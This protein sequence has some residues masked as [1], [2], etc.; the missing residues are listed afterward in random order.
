[1]PPDRLAA[2]LAA[3]QRRPVATGTLPGPAQREV[4]STA[5][6]MMAI[7]AS[8]MHP[9]DAK[10]ACKLAVRWC[11]SHKDACNDDARWGQLREIVFPNTIGDSLPYPEY[12]QSNKQ[13]FRML[14]QG[15]ESA[16][17]DVEAARVKLQ[18]TKLRLQQAEARALKLSEVTGQRPSHERF[19]VKDDAHVLVKYKTALLRLQVILW[20]RWRKKLQYTRKDP[21]WTLQSNEHWATWRSRDIPL[22]E[23]EMRAQLDALE[24]QEDSASGALGGD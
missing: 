12:I 21:D 7:L 14:C 15:L 3:G 6:L 22:T 18:R 2:V 8:R 9:G 19:I 10:E 24:E 17:W 1:M 13:W 4:V 16:I 5:D 20:D 23:E 11:A